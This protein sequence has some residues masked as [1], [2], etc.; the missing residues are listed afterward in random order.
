MKWITVVFFPVLFSAWPAWCLSSVVAEV[1]VY[2]AP[3][4]SMMTNVEISNPAAKLLFDTLP[5]FGENLTDGAFKFTQKTSDF[6]T[7]TRRTADGEQSYLCVMN[8]DSRG[9]LLPGVSADFGPEVG[10]V[11]RARGVG[12]VRVEVGSKQVK[13]LI[14]TQAAKALFSN[15]SIEAKHEAG[16]AVAVKSAANLNCS[17][18]LSPT[19]AE[20]LRDYSCQAVLNKRQR[21]LA[22]S[23]QSR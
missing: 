21:G 5:T 1:K 20:N 3:G 17:R 6:V 9:I 2:P 14:S 15:M 7:C 11:H 19:G 23:E 10:E 13:I 16:G 12:E 8:M 22:L 18:R 4:Q